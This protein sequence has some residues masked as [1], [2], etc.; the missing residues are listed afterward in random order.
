MDEE[1]QIKWESSE[2]VAGFRLHKVTGTHD[3]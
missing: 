3:V 2:S 1:S